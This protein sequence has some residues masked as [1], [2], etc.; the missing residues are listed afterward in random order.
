MQKPWQLFAKSLKWIVPFTPN[1]IPMRYD[2]WLYLQMTLRQ[3]EISDLIKVTGKNKSLSLNVD[4]LS[5]ELHTLNGY[6]L[7]CLFFIWL[8][9]IRISSYLNNLFIPFSF[10]L[11]FDFFL[12]LHSQHMKFLAKGWIG[13]ATESTPETQQQRIWVTSTAY[14]KLEAT[15]DP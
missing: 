10:F 5:I 9:S 15:L 2:I 14:A 4:S 7:Y 8:S 3:R 12:Q 11:S 6:Y 13:A 1:S